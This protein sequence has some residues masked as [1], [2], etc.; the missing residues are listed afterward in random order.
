MGRCVAGKKKRKKSSTECVCTV[1][2]CEDK[3]ASK[4]ARKKHYAQ[5]HQDPSLHHKCWRCDKEFEDA[6]S[7]RKHSRTHSNSFTCLICEKVFSTRF[8]LDR[9]VNSLHGPEA[10]PSVHQKRRSKMEELFVAL[11]AK[12]NTTPQRWDMLVTAVE[13]LG[14]KELGMEMFSEVLERFPS[15][16]QMWR[17][18]G[19]F[20]GPEDSPQIFKMV[21]ISRSPACV[22]DLPHG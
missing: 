22:N 10:D 18:F 4:P 17:R 19:E 20:A 16:V 14:E 21:C 15:W 2:G 6:Y 11:K 1:I 3:F 12:E 13:S 8:N 7:F 5:V 9:H